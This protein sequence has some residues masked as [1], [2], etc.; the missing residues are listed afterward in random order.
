M[1]GDEGLPV[2]YGGGKVNIEVSPHPSIVVLVDVASSKFLLQ[3][4][5]A[6]C[7]E[8]DQQKI[9][10]TF[11]DLAMVSSCCSSDR[12]VQKL[13]LPLQLKSSEV[14]TLD[15]SKPRDSPPGIKR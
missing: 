3:R 7:R 13:E 14:Q 10:H 12:L 4:K 2:V 6:H 5:S 11:L 1:N 8:V 9:S 15:Q